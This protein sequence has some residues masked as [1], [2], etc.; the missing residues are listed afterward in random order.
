MDQE[1][2]NTTSSHSFSPW[3]TNTPMRSPILDFKKIDDLGDSQLAKSRI[4][5]VER[6]ASL[7]IMQQIMSRVSLIDNYEAK[8]SKISNSKHFPKTTLGEEVFSDENF[9]ST[10]SI[11]T[12]LF[13]QFLSLNSLCDTP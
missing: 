1:S 8:I 11:S 4:N 12:I 10:N 13:V 5:K 6:K 7:Q 2:L 9:I 3:S